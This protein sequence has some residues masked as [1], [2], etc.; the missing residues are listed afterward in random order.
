VL[1]NKEPDLAAVADSVDLKNNTGLASDSSS[2][3]SSS[4]SSSSSSD[5]NSS[6]ED[7]G[8]ESLHA[9][10]KRYLIYI[11]SVNKLFNH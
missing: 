4:S 10:K 8:Q 9:H 7:S 1:K 11:F 3:S 5:G 6:E 2:C